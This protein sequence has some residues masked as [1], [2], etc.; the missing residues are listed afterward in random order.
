VKGGYFGVL[1]TFPSEL[2][3]T[4]WTA[5]FAWTTCFVITIVVSL[6]TRPRKEE[7]LVGLVYAL[8]PRPPSTARAFWEKP[9]FLGIITLILLLILNLLFA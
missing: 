8:T 1:E 7:E 5:I 4:F 3:Q 2:G 9:A 6:L